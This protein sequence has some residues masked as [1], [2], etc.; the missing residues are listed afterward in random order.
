MPTYDYRCAACGH[1]FEVFECVSAEGPRE[2]PRCK[3]Q[4][5]RRLMGGGLAPIVKRS[6]RGGG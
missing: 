4:R 3:K 6:P 5:S 2:C 1:V